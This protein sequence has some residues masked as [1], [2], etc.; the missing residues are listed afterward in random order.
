MEYNKLLFYLYACYMHN[1]THKRLI[2]M[3]F[4]I[5]QN[6]CC[7]TERL[8]ILSKIT[9]NIRERERKKDN[10]SKPNHEL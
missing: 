4:K 2:L 9:S 1:V 10:F 7:D 8:R 5:Q 6:I 3:S